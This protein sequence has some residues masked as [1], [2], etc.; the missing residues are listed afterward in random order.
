MLTA[1]LLILAQN[2]EP[3]AENWIRP[4][5]A[6][7]VQRAG[8]RSGPG[9]AFFEFAPASGAGMPA[10]CSTT[11]PTGAKGE[12][13][14]FTRASNGT[15]TKTAT[16]GLATTGI[17]NG[18]LVVLSSNQPRVSY[19]ANGTLGLLVES[20]RTNSALRSQE[21][22]NAAWTK[23][24]ALTITDN[25]ATSPDGATTASLLD[26]NAGVFEGVFQTITAAAGTYTCSA[27][28]KG[29]TST[30]PLI[31][32]QDVGGGGTLQ[33]TSP[34]LSTSTWTRVILTITTNGG[35]TGYRFFVYPQATA[36]GQGTIYAWGAQCEAGAYAT[37]YIPTVAA[38]V[39]RAAETASFPGA[40]WPVSPVSFAASV[41]APWSGTTT[42]SDIFFGNVASNSGWTLGWSGS[43]LR[44]QPCT[45]GVCATLD[46]AQ[47]PTALVTARWAVSYSGTQTSIL[48][49]GA[50]IA[51][52]TV[53]TAPNSPWATA[54][55]IGSSGFG[56]G[57]TILSRLCV[58]PDPSRCR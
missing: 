44:S 47:G 34:T 16:G 14:T 4:P 18:D 55:G 3:N 53:K 19:D 40:T 36:G 24:G 43:A 10:A 33:S 52:P 21:F 32:L 37:S 11:A 30:T 17:A 27:Y 58:D 45:A 31:Q 38:G 29:G 12:A 5:R 15:C 28:L 1:L 54:V 35:T 51:G 7:R 20:S 26:D 49:D 23:D 8:G 9:L 42:A 57:N 39:T 48:K 22:D 2:Q 25:N 13:L 6:E 50:L 41:T 56:Q 46:V